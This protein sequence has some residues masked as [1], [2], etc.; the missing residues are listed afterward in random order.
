MITLADRISK[1]EFAGQAARPA[2]RQAERRGSLP[3]STV[4]LGLKAAALFLSLTLF[5]GVA[6]AQTRSWPIV[7]G[8]ELQPT[9]QQFE[10]TS[11]GNAA[12]WTRWNS[13]VQPDVDRLYGQI[14]RATEQP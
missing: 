8:R 3:R 14:M 9:Q 1:T 11:S 5:V 4:A 7:N 13:R 2:S 6:A 12:D 10:N